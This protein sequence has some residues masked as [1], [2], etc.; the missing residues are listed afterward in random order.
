MCIRDSCIAVSISAFCGEVE[1]FT[2]LISL[3]EIVKPVILG[4]IKIMPVVKPC[5]LQLFIVY[6]KAHRLH[7]ISWIFE[8]VIEDLAPKRYGFLYIA[9]S[10][11]DGSDCYIFSH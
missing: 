3:K 10:P 6:L 4:Y 9:Y 11:Y 2:V 1:E 8:P 7:Y 5:V